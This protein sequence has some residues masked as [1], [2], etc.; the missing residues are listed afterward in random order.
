MY[1]DKRFLNPP[2]SFFDKPI[3]II[4]DGCSTNSTLEIAQK[5]TDKIYTNLLKHV[6]QVKPR[7]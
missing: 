3:I 2:S 7:V 1:R 4:A 5:Y 6:K